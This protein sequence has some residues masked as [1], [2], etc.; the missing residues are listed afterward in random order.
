MLTWVV[1]GSKRIR[2]QRKSTSPLRCECDCR[3][4]AT[5]IHTYVCAITTSSKL[6]CTNTLVKHSCTAICYTRSLL[7][8]CMLN[9]D[10]IWGRSLIALGCNEGVFLCVH[11][12]CWPAANKTFACYI[13]YIALPYYASRDGLHSKN[14]KYVN[15]FTKEL[16]STRARGNDIELRGCKTPSAYIYMLSTISTQQ[17]NMKACTFLHTRIIYDVCRN[18]CGKLGK[19]IGAALCMVHVFFLLRVCFLF[20]C[21]YCDTLRAWH[22]YSARTHSAFAVD[23]HKPQFSSGFN[24]TVRENKI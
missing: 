14:Q 10:S 6:N 9:L 12:G 24:E 17:R 8:C 5:H 23:L 4:P 1:G 11:F 21:D 16:A 19:W 15:A 20:S 13:R 18:D 7:S 2:K 3:A 22:A